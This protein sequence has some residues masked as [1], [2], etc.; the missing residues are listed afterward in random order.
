MKCT[1][2]SMF[3]C[4]IIYVVLSL[5]YSRV[6]SY[7]LYYDVH[8]TYTTYSIYSKYAA[9]SQTCTFGSINCITK[10]VLL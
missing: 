7:T 1:I 3:I 5:D 10:Y 8:T 4:L 6:N 9:L 2:V